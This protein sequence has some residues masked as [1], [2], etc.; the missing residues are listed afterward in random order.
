ME[1]R[2]KLIVKASWVSIGGNALLSVFKI[3]IGLIAGS[4][5]VVAD[6]IDSAGDI[7]ASAITLF[8]A[9]VVSRPPNLKFVYGYE[10]ADTIASKVLAFIIFFAGAQLAISTIHRLTE[11]ATGEIPS[12]MAIYVTIFSILGKL[13]LAWYQY[14]IGKKTGSLMLQANGRN[15]LGDVIISMAVLIGLF[16]T[17]IL[18]KPV[19]DTI[20][21]LMVSVWIMYIAFRIFRESSLELM[22]AVEDAGVY[23]RIFS[24]ISKVDGAYNPHRARVRKIGHRYMVAVDIEVDGEIPVKQAHLLA[25][26]VEEQIR[27]EL[28]DVYDVLVHTEPVGDDATDEKFGIS[29][30]NLQKLKSGKKK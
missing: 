25:H 30:D 4:L 23:D 12:L 29:Q 2:E 19:F 11:G 3:V 15:M 16:F 21:A 13:L 14:K 8:T 27:A 1:N 24:A 26:Q 20:T 9:H 28:E 22:D 6:G 7:V 17:F 10:R 18:K 5:A